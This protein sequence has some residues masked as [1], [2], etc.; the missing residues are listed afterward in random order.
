MCVS[1]LQPGLCPPQARCVPLARVW[2]SADGDG[3]SPLQSIS[4]PRGPRQ[5]PVVPRLEGRSSPSPGAT[6]AGSLPAP[7]TSFPVPSCSLF[8]PP[9]Q[10]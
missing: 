8:L 4:P 6:A 5:L 3:A 2:G 9:G 1:L 10:S 7:A